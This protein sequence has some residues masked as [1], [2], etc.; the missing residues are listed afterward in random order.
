[1]IILKIILFIT[2]IFGTLILIGMIGEK[3]I[4]KTDIKL[5]KNEKRD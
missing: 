1:M 3:F 2:I 4:K 5:K